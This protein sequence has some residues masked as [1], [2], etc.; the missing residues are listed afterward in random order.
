[1]NALVAVGLVSVL[2]VAISLLAVNSSSRDNSELGRW[3]AVMLAPVGCLARWRLSKLNGD[4]TWPAWLPGGTLLA[5]L[6]ASAVDFGLEVA[7]VRGGVESRVGRSLVAGVVGGLAGGLS[8]VSTW[9]ME[10]SDNGA[11]GIF[12]EMEQKESVGVVSD[13]VDSEVRI[14]AI[15]G[16]LLNGCNSR[17]SYR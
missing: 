9:A 1:M 14:L 6:L 3:V 15:V 12:G 17:W 16:W 7:V 10:V 8:T 4:R 11:W 2:A 13:W 5:N